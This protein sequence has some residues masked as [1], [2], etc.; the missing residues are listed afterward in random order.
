MPARPG[1]E[2]R[3]ARRTVLRLGLAGA[4]GAVLLTGC[5]LRVGSPESTR[6]TT[7]PSQPSTDERVLGAALAQADAL[8]ALYAR[9]AVVRPDLADALRLLGSEH[10]AH[11]RVLRP[12][13]GAAASGGGP[14]S[15]TTS[16]AAP[17]LTAATALSVL[18][19]A[20]RS[21]SAATLTDLA[22]VSGAAARLLASVS[23]CRSAHVSLLALLPTTPAR[24][25][26]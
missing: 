17:A 22:S 11:V 9:A 15:P 5:Q 18:A 26:K 25:A 3:P 13:A 24:A 21:A 14:A 8:A 10:T 6:A 1:P 4:G 20:E 2:L 7:P 19:Q 16:G 12:L 23:A